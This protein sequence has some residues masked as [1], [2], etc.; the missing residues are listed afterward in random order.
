[1]L[2]LY[3]NKYIDDIFRNMRDYYAVFCG[4]QNIEHKAHRFTDEYFVYL[5][6]MLHAMFACDQSFIDYD[7]NYEK[8][9]EIIQ[10][11]LD[12]YKID[13]F[14]DL[15]AV[16][17][18]LISFNSNNDQLVSMAILNRFHCRYRDKKT[19]TLYRLDKDIKLFESSELEKLYKH[20]KAKYLLRPS[21]DNKALGTFLSLI[22]KDIA[23]SNRFGID[24]YLLKAKYDISFVY[25]SMSRRGFN[26]EFDYQQLQ[27]SSFDSDEQIALQHE[28]GS[29]IVSS[30]INKFWEMGMKKQKTDKD[31][32]SYILYINWLKTGFM[33]MDSYSIQESKNQIQ[34]FNDVANSV[35]VPISDK[36]FKD[37]LDSAD[38]V[39]NKKKVK[40]L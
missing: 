8:T 17:D 4:L 25:E 12:K 19:D 31:K 3:D 5:N 32:A 38:E 40:Q 2:N 30:C 34:N 16:I 26:L 22:D 7:P 10:L 36:I 27:S 24:R 20:E 39:S 33:L 14:G 37:I 9:D 21:V 23:V 13:D 11:L 18:R 28:I 29:S 6:Y 15:N 1:M 35:N